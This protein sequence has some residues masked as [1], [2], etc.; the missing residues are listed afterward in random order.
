MRILTVSEYMKQK[1]GQKVYRLSLSSGCTCPNRDGTLGWGGCAF[2]SAGGSGDFATEPVSVERQIAEAKKRVD[3]KFP[4][5]VS[6]EERKYI[7][8]FQSYTNTYGKTDHLRRIFTEAAERPE[9]VTLS[10][11]TRPDCLEQ[12][13]VQMLAE[14][15]HIKPVW[16][17]LGLQTIHEQT[18][19]AFHRGYRLPVFLDAYRRLKQAGLEVIVHV[20]LGLPG[21]GREDMLETVRFLAGLNPGLDGIKLQLL[22]I[23]K[24]T[25]YGS[26]FERDPSAF[27]TS[28]FT[29]ESYCDLVVACLKLLPPETV[30]HR[31]TG[32][33]PKN[34]L[35][36]PKWSADKKKVLNELNRRIREA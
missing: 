26:I 2:C 17:E 27:Q 35:L 9:I 7:A 15:N 6:P 28:G 33:G 3:S 30:I 16:V 12:D 5:S 31:L 10:V 23:L 11:G 19:E 32:D 34:L 1:Y 24:G 21:E 8:Y 22:H 4:R 36:A 18:A 14:L 20:I 29:L 13:K 25:E